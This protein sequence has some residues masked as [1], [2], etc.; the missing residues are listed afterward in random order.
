MPIDYSHAR[1]EWL[2][3][4]RETLQGPKDGPEEVLPHS[5]LESYSSGILVP[6]A[7]RIPTDDEDAQPN[8]QPDDTVDNSTRGTAE[9]S[10]EALVEEHRHEI[11]PTSAVGLS[12][13]VTPDIRLEVIV[14]GARYACD[15]MQSGAKRSW[16][17][18]PVVAVPGAC[19]FAPP[20]QP[21]T[22]TRPA[23]GGCAEVSV[24]WRLHQTNW[25]VTVAL[26]NRLP[27]GGGRNYGEELAS[28]SLF[29]V[30]LACVPH[31]GRILPYPRAAGVRLTPDE[32]E[33]ELQYRHHQTFGLGHG[34]AADW[35]HGDHDEIREL[36]TSFLPGVKVP[37][38]TTSNPDLPE[39]ALDLAFLS[40]CCERPCEVIDKLDEFVNCYAAWVEAG[41]A[42]YAGTN[43]PDEAVANRIT[44]RQRLAVERMRRG[45]KLLRDDP[46]VRRAFS[47]S[48]KAMRQQMAHIRLLQG[49]KSGTATFRWRPFQLAF[50]LLALESVVDPES[51]ERDLVDLLWFPTGG[52]KTEAYL[53]LIALLVLH[54]RLRWPGT[55][56]GTTV[57]MRY[58]LRLLTAQQ[59]QRA[60]TLIC[61]LELLRREASRDLGEEPITGGLWVGG[62]S[63]PNRN[64]EARAILT[65]LLA[66]LSPSRGLF[67]DQCP[68]CGTPLMPPNHS[69]ATPQAFGVRPDGTGIAFFCPNTT[70]EFHENLPL[71]VVDEH[72]YAHPPTLL[73]ATVDKFA[74]LA[75]EDRASAFFGGTRNRPPEMIIQDELHLIAGPLGSFAGLYEAAIDTVIRIKADIRPKYIA[76]TATI[77]HAKE[78]VRRL[79]GRDMAIFPPPGHTSDDSFFARTDHTRPGRLYVGLCG[80]NPFLNWRE[81]LALA[82][83]AALAIP[84]AKRW[85]SDLQ[86]AWWTTVIYHGSLRG[87][88]QSHRLA[89]HDI[90][91]HVNR[92]LAEAAERGRP[93]QQEDALNPDETGRTRELFQDGQITELTSRVPAAGIQDVIRRLQKPCDDPEAISLVL[94][95]NMLSVGIDI[96][97]LAMMIVNGQPLTTAEYIQASSRVGRDRVPGVVLVNYNRQPRDLSHFENF[98][99][100]HESFYRFVEPTSVTPFSAPA[101]H[102]A[103]HAALVIIMRHGVGLLHN[104]DAVRMNPADGSV[105]K[106]IARFIARCQAAEPTSSAEVREQAD[107]LLAEWQSHRRNSLLYARLPK[108]PMLPSL[109]RDIFAPPEKGL[110]ETMQSMRS[111]DRVCEMRIVRPH[112]PGAVGGR[113]G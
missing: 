52:G 15:K 31:Q 2:S 49:H 73:L 85:Q 75:W 45:C 47:L 22:V 92:L 55:C 70:C 50:V 36:S 57:I 28:A 35:V 30:R 111:V 82:A 32:E 4:M 72:L 83:G 102:L 51:P 29:Q 97:R 1:D 101:R 16:R 21:S 43:R 78:Q 77:R 56:N 17:R 34:V 105:R 33:L 113:H 64:D 80:Q 42:V 23:L 100:Y 107:R 74:R 48:Q 6:I 60:T 99:P 103:L 13:L 98:R 108:E 91:E 94:C 24:R 9:H 3:W 81:T 58:T 93:A 68:W 71:H 88:G 69:E 86:D 79:Y 38:V 61:A 87:V 18:T 62:A 106:A 7:A 76:S 10:E 5:P 14:E 67:L 110:W 46:L 66:G 26:V 27:I 44:D 104:D 54:R 112:S 89:L 63:T 96:S 109:L 39:Q 37:L 12:F 65:D 11:M 53:A 90:P 20:A 84:V 25:L 40:D 95:T 41:S 59:F 8:E 19:E